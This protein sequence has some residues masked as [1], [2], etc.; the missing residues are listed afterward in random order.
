MH[1]SVWFEFFSGLF[2]C[3]TLWYMGGKCDNKDWDLNCEHPFSK[4]SG[5]KRRSDV[6][7]FDIMEFRLH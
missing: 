7:E 1:V 5:Y 2:L 3:Q 6:K 4:V